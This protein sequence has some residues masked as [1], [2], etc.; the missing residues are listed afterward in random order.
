MARNWKKMS[1]E[2]ENKKRQE[3]IDKAIET[4]NKGVYE[5]LDSDRFKT[6]LDTM[7]KFHDYSLNNTLLILG[8]NPRATQLASYTKWQKDFNRQVKS[9]EKGLKIWVPVEYT[10]KEKNL[11]MTKMAI[12]FQMIM[13]ISLI[14]SLIIWIGKLNMKTIRMHCFLKMILFPKLKQDVY[15]RWRKP[16]VSTIFLMKC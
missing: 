6:L 15:C 7:S 16:N 14:Q 12:E 13:E 10:V 4:M 8:Q 9:G 2:D 11:F 1:K 3:T 5:Y